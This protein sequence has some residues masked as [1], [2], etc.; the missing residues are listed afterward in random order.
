MESGSSC[1]KRPMPS[2]TSLNDGVRTAF[3]NGIISLS[4]GLKMTNSYDAILV[5]VLVSVLAAQPSLF[6]VHGAR[7]SES[8]GFE[9]V[10]QKGM[11]YR[12]YPFPYDSS[13]SNESLER[14]A[15]TN[16]EYVAVT[17][18]WLQENITA[19]Q[20]YRK[21]NWTAT[22]AALSVAIAKAHQLGMKVMLK[23]MVDPEDVYAH[24]R[25]E[26]PSSLGWF[27]N[28]EAFI[29]SYA[30][31]AQD[32]R[33]DLFSVGC[34]FKGTEQEEA[35]WRRII[36]KVKKQYSGP[37]TYAATFDSFQSITWWD[38]LD[39]IGI[40]AYFPLASKKDPS[41]TEL[42]E[43]WNR[44]AYSIE[45]WSST[46]KK[47]II[48]AEIGYRSGDGNNI[49]PA[50]WI[51]PLTPD[52]QEQFDS[53]SAAFQVLWNK[54]WFYGFYWW[55]WESN[56]NA[57]GLNDADFTPQNKPVESLIK[58]WYSTER[59]IEHPLN[60]PWLILSSALLSTMIVGTVVLITKKLADHNARRDQ[61]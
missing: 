49:E 52:M 1:S 58:D 46:I 23:P 25:V 39:Y 31:F 8:D 15:A 3:V 48:L 56:P 45:Q 13:F 27:N 26:I 37:L 24:N 12:H 20:I 22:D 4:M 40:D 50:N 10:F 57:G 21:T 53:Y 43:A 60:F 55:I 54:P 36:D 29:T 16:T 41:L 7:V 11:S 33:V 61:S 32:T 47:P 59:V 30:R 34:E 2:T 35:S 51:A 18:W 9:P 6:C 14:M 42:K 44:I 5:C 38:S 17:V 28:Y 19:T